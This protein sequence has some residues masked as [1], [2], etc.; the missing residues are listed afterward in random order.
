MKIEKHA[1]VDFSF[2]KIEIFLIF[3]KIGDLPLKELK[4]VCIYSFICKMV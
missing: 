4:F 3:R 1:K 2:E